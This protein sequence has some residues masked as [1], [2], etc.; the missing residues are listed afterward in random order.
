MFEGDPSI[1]VRFADVTLLV[2]G[3]GVSASDS[4]GVT[5]R[6]VNGD[7]QADL[8][9][10]VQGPASHAIH[11]VVLEPGLPPIVD[12]KNVHGLGSFVFTSLVSDE[13]NF[14]FGGG[15][16]PCAFFDNSGPGDVG[17][18][19]REL[20]GGDEVETWTHDV[21]GIPFQ[22]TFAQITF[23]TRETFSDPGL[24]STLDF[25]LGAGSEF[26]EKYGSDCTGGCICAFGTVH[27]FTFRGD[28][29]G[30]LPDGS[31]VVTFTE[32]GDDVGLDYGRLTIIGT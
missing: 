15:S 8:H 21:S 23:E 3:L 18:F 22:P 4:I 7:G 2:T 32:N 29:S 28:P 13:D 11:H 9:V 25:D 1:L 6:D 17:V 26:L 20:S 10:D 31:V 30:L 12:V 14:G 16:V 27:T 5:A 19:D 24:D